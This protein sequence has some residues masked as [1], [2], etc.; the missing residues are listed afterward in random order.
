M[1]IPLQLM[2]LTI[3]SLVYII[4]QQRRGQSWIESI[5][6]IGWKGS[7]PVLYLWSLGLTFILT[8]LGWIAFRSIPAEILS[9]PNVAVS[10]YIDLAPTLTT[11]LIILF[12]EAFQVALGEEIFFRGFLGGWLFRHFGF[13][14]GNAL[15]SIIFLLPHLFLLLASTSLW[16]ILPVQ[17]LAGWLYGWLRYRSDSI[18]PG[19]LS[20]S[21]VN[22]LGAF[23]AIGT[24]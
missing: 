3:P 8:T 21:L 5:R 2:L 10:E 24:F 16:P 19:W 20:H 6:R 4:V 18:L 17:F 12:R 15:Q 22:T 7:P 13:M 11:F 9:H 1:D 23:F 14:V